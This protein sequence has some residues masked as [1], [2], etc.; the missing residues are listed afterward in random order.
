MQEMLYPDQLS[1]IEGAGQACALL[2][3]GRFS[4]GTSGLSIGHASPEAAEGG[5]DRAGREMATGSKSTFPRAPS[6]CGQRRGTG[7]RRAAQDAKGWQPAKERP[8]KVSVAL[9]GLCRDDHQ[10][11]ARRDAP[12]ASLQRLTK[13]RLSAPADDAHKY[14][15]GLVAVVAGEMAGASAL[16]AEAA[17]RGGAGYVKL[18]GAQ[19]IVTGSHAIVRAS[20]KDEA[21]LSDKRIAAL[22]VGPGLGRRE[23]GAERLGQALM[24]GHA[25]VL[26][27]DALW[28]LSNGALAALPDKA[29]LTPMSA[30]SRSFLPTPVGS[31]SPARRSSRRLPPPG[32]RGGRGA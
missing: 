31:T 7:H 8:R 29:I 1:E 14:T 23:S 27:A 15:R 12:E 28:H 19:A 4:G 21:A 10:R 25:A 13:P 6:T 9:A 26:D 18:V 22:L 2:T 5:D 3:D 16:S 30:N 17:A 32:A 20:M 11:R 24:H